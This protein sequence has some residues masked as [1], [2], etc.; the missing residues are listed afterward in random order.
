MFN[1]IERYLVD[2]PTFKLWMNVFGKKCARSKYNKILKN[3]LTGVLLKNTDIF[4]IYF[5]IHV[6]STYIIRNKVKITF[7]IVS[8]FM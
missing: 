5:S 8:N 4:H 7:K 3:W 2:I 6:S 1:G